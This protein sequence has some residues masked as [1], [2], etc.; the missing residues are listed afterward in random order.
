M[1]LL[2]LLTA[3]AL[4]FKTI[5]LALGGK[6]KEGL[7]V[8]PGL[9]RQDRL[10]SVVNN[11]RLLS[12]KLNGT[13]SPWDCV[14]YIY[15]FREYKPSITSIWYDK[16]SL[17]YISSLCSVIEHPGKRI[18]ENMHMVQAPLI[19]LSYHYVFLLLDDCELQGATE[20]NLDKLLAVMEYNSLTIASPFVQ[21]A[22]RGG[23]QQFRM[24]MQ[25]EPP[26]GTEGFISTFVEMFAW[27]MTM[28]A[29]E[30]L[31]ELFYPAINPYGWGFDLW[32]A[33][34]ARYSECKSII[35]F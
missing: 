35:Y 1:R 13:E 28:D 18:T 30:A 6:A 21:G 27:V 20:F 12:H 26:L 14:I 15:A 8:I 17:A 22:N 11:L 29:Y 23:G 33:P 25:T 4:D 7:L 19:R 16:A 5:I 32:Y 3:L 34:Q 24:I 10:K 31:W 2:L 9:G